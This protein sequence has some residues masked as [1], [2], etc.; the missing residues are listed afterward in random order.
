MEKGKRLLLWLVL[1]VLVPLWWHHQLN[2]EAL[3]NMSILSTGWIVYQLVLRKSIKIIILI[4]LVILSSFF[5][6]NNAGLISGGKIDL[7]RSYWVDNENQA[8]LTKFQQMS[9][10]LPFR[11]RNIVWGNWWQ[12]ADAILRGLSGLGGEKL[13]PVIGPALWF[14]AIISLY[15]RT[16]WEVGIAIFAIVT[17]GWLS[18]NPNTGLIGIYLLPAMVVMSLPAIKK[19]NLKI[20]AVLS[21]ITLPFIF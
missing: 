3:L 15:Y 10:F 9:L 21:L 6:L 12:I 16:G 8:E 5:L 14:L 13:W 20:L 11:S 4:I 7:S 1:I 17:A 18:R 19:I 2:S